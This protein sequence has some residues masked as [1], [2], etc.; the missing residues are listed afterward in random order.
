MLSN[1][2]ATC[3]VPIYVLQ[4]ESYN[5]AWGVSYQRATTFWKSAFKSIRILN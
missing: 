2:A 1:E 4:A 3:T 5:L